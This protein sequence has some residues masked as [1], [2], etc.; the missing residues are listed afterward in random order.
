MD[1]GDI[2]QAIPARVSKAKRDGRRRKPN[3]S[4]TIVSFSLPTDL[5]DRID[6]L[7]HSDGRSRS[8]YVARALNQVLAA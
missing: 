7:A 2:K 3:N 5:V 4:I 6:Q 8:S 1:A